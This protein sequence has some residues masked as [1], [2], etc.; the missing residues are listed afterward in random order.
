MTQYQGRLELTWT[1]KQLRLLAHEDGSYEWV[2]PSDYRVAEVRLLHDVASAGIVGKRRAADN[3][4]IRGDALHALTGLAMLPEFATEYLGKVRL[5][6]IDPPFNTGQAFTSYD[7]NL[8]H[9]VWLTMLRDRLLQVKQL[10]TPD[11]SVWV[12]LDDEEV[13]RFRC[14]LDEVFGLDNFVATVIWQ[15]AYSPRN[16]APSL[17]TDQDYIL[18]YSNTPDWRSNR[19]ARVAERDALYKAPDGDPHPWVSGDPAA[20]SAYR[21]QTWVYAIQSPFTGD[22]VYPAIG[23]C[24]GSKQETMK[25]MVEEWGVEYRLVDLDDARKRALICGVPVAEVRAGVQALMVKGDLDAAR[26][27]AECRYA[28]GSWPRLYFTKGG[29]GGLKLKRYLD[30]ISQSTAPRTLWFNSEVGHNRT[31]KAEMNGLFPGISVFATPK[32]E[33]LLQRIL[34]IGTNPG[35]IVLDCFLGSGTT[36]AVAH[37]MGRRWVG[38]EREPATIETY[39]LPRLRK[40][41][42]G[43]DS[44]GITSIETLTGEDLPEGINPGE[45]RAAAKVLDAWAKAEALPDLGE[46]DGLGA[47]TARALA[48]F[49]RAADKTRQETTW[50]GGGGFRVL[51]VSPSMFEVDEGLVFLADWM[52][53]G[54]LAEATAAQLGFEYEMDPPFAGRK[55]RSRLAVVDG[56]VNE[57][58]VRLVVSALPERQRVV[59]CGTGIDTDARPVLRDLRPGSTLRKIPAALLDEYRSARQ[60]RL[61]LAGPSAESVAS[62]NGAPAGAEGIR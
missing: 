13:H 18:I 49:L 33:R 40:V 60:L 11:G 56:V 58:V 55:G 52:S 5:C 17:S 43:E 12:H 35:D 50:F 24:W 39:A 42:A 25:E 2:E 46:L 1:N 62:S 51:E 61:T 14:V 23:R 31:A 27:R 22:L 6:Y 20:P 44:G 34:Q 15:K 30:K 8:E 48:K 37:K 21:N 53:N 4:L 16:D 26:E 54:A 57:A 59:I 36:A 47:V 45:S 19:L 28:E 10:L 41:V 9:S 7:D 3:L 32:P 29:K 38:I